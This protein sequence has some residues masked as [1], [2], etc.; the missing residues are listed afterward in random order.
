MK[1]VRGNRNNYDPKSAKELVL[2][3]VLIVSVI[4]LIMTFTGYMRESLIAA[5]AANKYEIARTEAV[6]PATHEVDFTVVNASGST[7]TSWIY[8]PGTQIDYPLVQGR[9]NDTYLAMDAYG[10]KSAAGAIF[11]N[12]ANSPD[13]TDDKTV[14]FGHNMKDG[15][16]FTQLHQYTDEEWGKQ[17]TDCYIYMNDGCVNHYKVRY[18][19]FTDPADVAVYVTSKAEKAEDAAEQLAAEAEIVY[20]AYTGG[21]LIC[22]STCTYHT[23]RTV[24]VYEL[25]DHERPIIGMTD[26]MMTSVSEMAVNKG[27][28]SSNK[29]EEGPVT[30]RVVIE[31]L[32]REPERADHN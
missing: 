25:V 18:Y 27:L 15:S 9:D 5:S 13:M 19:L 28:V 16:M 1:I 10:K 30:D 14:I 20:G 4:A 17:H 24:I 3:T 23:Q 8:I 12:Y 11:I 7:S 32:I 2:N 26:K 22:L 31:D 6:N 29:A 21:K